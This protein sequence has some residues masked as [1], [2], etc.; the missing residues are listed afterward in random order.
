MVVKIRLIVG[1]I[2][3]FIDKSL[4]FLVDHGL[5]L[6]FLESLMN[7]VGELL[8]ILNSSHV[9]IFLGIHA[10][11]IEPGFFLIQLLLERKHL[12]GLHK[13]LVLGSNGLSPV[14][15]ESFK[16]VFLLQS[17]NNILV[18]QF[19]VGFQL[20]TL[21][22]LLHRA[23]VNHV[24]VVFD[25]FGF[26]FLFHFSFFF[27]LLLFSLGLSLFGFLLFLL[28]LLFFFG[29]LDRHLFIETFFNG[30]LSQLHKAVLVEFHSDLLFELL[31]SD[32][33]RGKLI[34]G[35]SVVKSW[36]FLIIR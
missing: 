1:K 7:R 24:R 14:V 36:N 27:L 26:K 30:V 23:L 10:F 2:F 21:I 22:D 19:H 20:Q 28:F 3:I 16:V 18:I 25:L 15:D 32:R 5:E 35:Q 29:F 8:Q 11:V 13:L 17:L 34:F 9:F 31:L 12:L 4:E 33:S 6:E